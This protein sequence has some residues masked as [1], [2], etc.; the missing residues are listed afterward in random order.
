MNGAER[1]SSSF[2][3]HA[4]PRLCERLRVCVGQVFESEVIILLFMFAVRPE[5]LWFPD[6]HTE[7]MEERERGANKFSTPTRSVE[8]TRAGG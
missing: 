8:T 7:H 3:A 1:D 6:R 5:P 2:R 4:R